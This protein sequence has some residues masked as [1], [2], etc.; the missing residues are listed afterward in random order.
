[1]GESDIGL[2]L[3]SYGDPAAVPLAVWLPLIE[4]AP[5]RTGYTH[6]WR[7]F[8]NFRPYVMASVD[9]T[10][11]AIEAKAAGWAY[12]RVASRGDSKRIRGEGRCPAAEESGRRVTCESCPIQCQ[13][14][15]G[16]LAGRVIQAHGAR[17][18]RF[19]AAP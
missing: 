4:A 18:G 6:D 10:A 1:M 7:R 3:G 19:T 2:R 9:S 13:G 8:P 17:A 12:F 16:A 5:W 15:E 11:E 14:S